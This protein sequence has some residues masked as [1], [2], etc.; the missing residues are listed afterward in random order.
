VLY[1]PLLYST[2]LCLTLLCLI[3]LYINLI[4]FTSFHLASFILLCLN[5][6]Y[7]TLRLEICKYVAI[8][9]L[10]S[11]Y[12]VCWP[13]NSP[14]CMNLHRLM[15]TFTRPGR[16]PYPEPK[17]FCPYS[18]FQDSLL[19]I[20]ISTHHWKPESNSS[21]PSD[22]QTEAPSSTLPCM[23]NALVDCAY[24]SAREPHV[25]N[26]NKATCYG[27]VAVLAYHC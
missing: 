13:G 7:F 23:V 6:V 11:W 19:C 12:Y 26:V 21:F 10:R 1:L 16:S 25:R 22:V 14:P 5:L 17:R 27:A 20:L 15:K 18:Q 3:S 4:Y 2:L 8:P 24:H 9:S